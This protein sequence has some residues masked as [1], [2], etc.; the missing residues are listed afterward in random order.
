MNR[1]IRAA[2]VGAI[3]GMRSSA[4][5]LAAQW[6]RHGTFPL[7]NAVAFAGEVVADKLPFT[8]S[9]T[10]I[11]PLVG[12]AGAA[13]YGVRRMNGSPRSIV[14]DGV[15]VGAA[16]GSAF[17]FRYLRGLA[18]TRGTRVALGAA[19]FEDVLCIGLVSVLATSP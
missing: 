8:P 11:G 2:L 19:L 9:R 13:V 17:L 1:Y 10:T 18:S 12:R 7:G 15:A 4:G 16:V 6:K 14:V 5:P 3:S